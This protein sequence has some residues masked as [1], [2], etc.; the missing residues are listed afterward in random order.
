MPQGVLHGG[1]R[2]RVRLAHM[3]AKQEVIKAAQDR[4]CALAAG[5]ADRLRELLH[6]KFKWTTHE[7]QTFDRSE[8]IHR[9]TEGHTVWRSQALADAEVVVV[10]ETAVLYAEVTDVVMSE[11][12]EPMTF[13]MPV[14]QV[15]AL[16]DGGWKCL[17]GH[18]GPRRS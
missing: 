7:G 9:N 18:A 5:D 10:G 17:G 16:L 15:W 6:E 14:T 3:D 4:A 12:D 11:R 1:H 13:R 2:R 8:Y